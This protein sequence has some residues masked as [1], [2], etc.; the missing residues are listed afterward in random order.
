MIVKCIPKTPGKE[1]C[2]MISYCMA[3][4]NDRTI[5]GCGIPLYAAGLI[6]REDIQ[7]EHTLKE[8]KK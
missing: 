3:R 4:L 1:K 7:V 5:T 8:V 2:P 6:R